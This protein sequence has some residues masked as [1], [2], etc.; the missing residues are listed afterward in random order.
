MPEK[1]EKGRKEAEQSLKV[2]LQSVEGFKGKTIF[3]PGNHDWY[4]NRLVGLKEE[5]KFIEKA[6]GK[7]AFLPENG[8]PI[9]SVDVSDQV[10]LVIV[11]TQWYIENWNKNPTINDD[12]E[13]KTEALFFDELEGEIKKAQGKTVV[14]S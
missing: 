14:T 10:Q 13:I 4:A 8:C 12:C 11:D 3:I 5:E 9:E 7:N 6:L 2:Q 1:D